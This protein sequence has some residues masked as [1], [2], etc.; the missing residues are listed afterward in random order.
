MEKWTGIFQQ[1]G[2]ILQPG[3]ATFQQKAETLQL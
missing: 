2:E 3:A 1:I